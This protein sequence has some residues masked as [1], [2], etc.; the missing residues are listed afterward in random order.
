M[1]LE[2][3]RIETVVRRFWW[4]ECGWR[5]KDVRTWSEGSVGGD[6][7]RET[8]RGIRFHKV[9]LEPFQTLMRA[10]RSE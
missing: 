8:K 2:K 5:N 6:V 9:L 7:V 10:D 4:R 1:G 3:Q